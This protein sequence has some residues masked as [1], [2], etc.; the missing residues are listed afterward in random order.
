MCAQ[1]HQRTYVFARVNAVP[2]E[3]VSEHG[4]QLSARDL[5]LTAKGYEHFHAR[6]S[7]NIVKMLREFCGA[8]APSL[9]AVPSPVARRVRVRCVC[10]L[11]SVKKENACAIS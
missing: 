3:S 2:Q 1:L 8:C 5:H 10:I 11:R 4:V 6:V 9:P 7:T